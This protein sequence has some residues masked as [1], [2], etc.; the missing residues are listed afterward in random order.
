VL[1]RAPLLLVLCCGP[2]LQEHQVVQSIDGRDSFIWSV[3]RHEV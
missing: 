1:A 3:R 2:A